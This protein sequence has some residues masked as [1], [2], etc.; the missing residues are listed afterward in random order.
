MYTDVRKQSTFSRSLAN[1]EKMGA[2][3]TDTEMCRRIGLLFSFPEEEEV[4]VLEPSIGDAK[5]V[6]EVIGKTEG[7][8]ENIKLFGVELNPVTHEGVRQNALVDYSINGDFLKGIKVS[9]NSFSFC[10]SNPPYGRDDSGNR[11]ERLFCEKIWNYLSAKAILALVIP[12]YVLTDESFLKSFFKNYQPFATFRFDDA[13]YQQFK[14]VVVIAQ[15][16]ASVGYLRQTY[17]DYY[18]TIDSLE[19]LPY[20]PTEAPEKR[21]KVMSSKV[22]DI[23]YFTT[24]AFDAAK[25]GEHLRNSSLYELLGEKAFIPSFSATELG[26][27]PMPLKKDLLYL[28]AIAGGGQGLVGSEENKD[29]HLQRG[30]AKVVTTTE[31]RL[32]DKGKPEI[33]EKSFTKIGLNVIENDGRITVLE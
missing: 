1:E 8:R 15:K 32:N 26:H 22:E 30:I 25:A 10:F 14:Q 3:F 29:L 4:C 27:P 23:E 19:K 33:V 16:R 12:Y 9:H 24:L 13:V 31:T 6:L 21:I 20:L 17:D 2:Y 28:T 18:S 11:L 5:A 7:F